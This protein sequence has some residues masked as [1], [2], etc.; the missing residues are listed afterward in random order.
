MPT[1][2][3]TLREM[4][5]S[6]LDGTAVTPQELEFVMGDGNATIKYGNN[7]NY[8]L[9]RGKIAG[10]SVTRG[11]DMPM[12]VSL[13]GEFVGFKA[14]GDLLA[15]MSPTEFLDGGNGDV[16]LV[17]TG[18]NE[19]DP[20]ACDIM[21]EQVRDSDCDPGYEPEV[22]MLNEF[23]ADSVDVDLKAGT[24]NISGKCFTTRPVS[25]RA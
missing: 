19:C 9:N 14:R 13:I 16:S 25:T 1:E 4:T 11:D 10:G 8:R 7:Y 23:R 6:F 22:T 2:V 3:L 17:S 24:M 21:I 12:E 5:V 15:D 18:A 20:F